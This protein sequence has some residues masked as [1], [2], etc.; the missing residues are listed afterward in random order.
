M[1]DGP[2][3]YKGMYTIFPTNTELEELARHEAAPPSN[4]IPGSEWN[5]TEDW[6][7]LPKALVSDATA[8]ERALM[9]T[10][11]DASADAW[12]I[13]TAL[14]NVRLAETD[15]QKARALSDLKSIY[16]HYM[17]TANTDLRVRL[18]VNAL[19]NTIEGDR[20][21]PV[22]P[23]N[24]DRPT[25]YPSQERYYTLKPV[26]AMIDAVRQAFKRTDS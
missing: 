12:K 14:R 20:L 8:L 6:Q 22:K 26:F 19:A 4:P 23:G 1:I 16:S 9:E 24:F 7:T 18:A 10:A 11:N 17:K 2:G 25:A 13:T 21:P 15:K 5:T 3:Y